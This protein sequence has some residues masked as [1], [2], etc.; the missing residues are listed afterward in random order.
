MG[1][2]ITNSFEN[3]FVVQSDSETPKNQLNV[4]TKY[5]QSFINAQSIDFSTT[6]E[7]PSLQTLQENLKTI[8]N[9]KEEAPLS[10]LSL[11]PKRKPKMRQN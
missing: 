1:R 9:L 11:P 8:E 4:N 5:K 2:D 10:P 7:E 3:N 6:K